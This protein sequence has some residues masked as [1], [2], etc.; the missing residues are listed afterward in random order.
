MFFSVI[1]TS[2]LGY[3]HSTEQVLYRQYRVAR[4]QPQTERTEAP[5]K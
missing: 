3:V 1:H 4:P 5:G 2:A